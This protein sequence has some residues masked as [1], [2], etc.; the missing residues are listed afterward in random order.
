MPDP[1]IRDEK[2]KAPQPQGQV[3]EEETEKQPAL[4][5]MSAA[6]AMQPSLAPSAESPPGSEAFTMAQKNI[7]PDQQPMT[8]IRP[9][10][11]VT[12]TMTPEGEPDGSVT[13]LHVPA[14][15]ANY[16]HAPRVWVWVLLAII[17]LASVYAALDAKTTWMPFHI[18][19]NKNAS[20]TTP[21]ATTKQSSTATTGSSLSTIE[22]VRG[23]FTI[24]YPSSNWYLQWYGPAGASPKSSTTLD[25]NEQQIDF[26]YGSISNTSYILD[27]RLNGNPASD[28]N[29]TINNIANGSTKALA[30]GLSVW[31]SNQAAANGCIELQLVSDSHFYYKL[32]NGLYLSALGT[33]C[34]NE[35]TSINLTV[36]QQT[37]SNQYSQAVQI[38]GSI[39]TH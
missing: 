15:Q 29:T 18:F 7:F 5:D 34:W 6:G 26:L 19:S 30:N 25:G 12:K 9:M 11:P 31:T 20:V 33:F 39:K 2:L 37:A 8:D 17:I 22:S 16:H 1:M 27:L 23:G 13:E 38:L 21:P 3:I 14:G 36:A 32:P 28:G 35:K 24:K 10:P 4:G